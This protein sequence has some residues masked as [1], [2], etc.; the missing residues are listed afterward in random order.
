M[1]AP[2]ES[3]LARLGQQLERQGLTPAQRLAVLVALPDELWD[4]VWAQLRQHIES[5]RA[6]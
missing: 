3:V 6:A 4:A 2:D 1:S 5:Q